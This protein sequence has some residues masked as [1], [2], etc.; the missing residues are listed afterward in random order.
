LLHRKLNISQTEGQGLGVAI[1]S[2]GI[3]SSRKAYRIT[4]SVNDTSGSI[5]FPLLFAIIHVHKGKVKKITWDD[6]CNF[7]DQG[8][9]D[10]N[11][12]TF[13][14][15]VITDTSITSKS[16]YIKDTTCTGN[17][18]AST[19]ALCQL[20]VFVSWTGTDKNGR[21]FESAANRFSRLSVDN[22]VEYTDNRLN[23]N[24]IY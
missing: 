3:M 15:T 16:C 7:C 8:L 4:T 21:K 2:M 10:F 12:Y 6:N 17:D 5:T 13:E 20:Q 22:I 14:G 9:C 18:V 1:E 19:N 23:K 11:M 24:S